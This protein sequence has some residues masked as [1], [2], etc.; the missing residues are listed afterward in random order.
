MTCVQGSGLRCAAIATVAIACATSCRDR[1]V[2]APTVALSPLPV[3]VETLTLEPGSYW[4][5]VFGAVISTTPLPTCRLLAFTPGGTSVITPVRLESVNAEWV[6]RSLPGTGTVDLRFAPT[7][8]PDVRGILVQ[9]TLRGV[10]LDVSPGP[11]RPTY[12]NRVVA[13]GA[14]GAESATVMGIGSSATAYVSGEAQGQMS[15][16]D[17]IGLTATCETLRW[18]LQMRR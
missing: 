12:D 14:A 3:P 7:D 13:R 16:L 9:G 6:A 1:Q 8:A 11:P 18:S 2:V 15:F 4:L 5:E 10:G 17:R